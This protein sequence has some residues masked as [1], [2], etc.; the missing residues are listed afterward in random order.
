GERYAKLRP[1]VID[2]LELLGRERAL[3]YKT[4]LLTGLRKSELASLTVAQLQLDSEPPLVELEAADEKNREG[5]SLPLRPDLAA[6]LKAW[7][8][9]WLARLQV[10]AREKGDPIPTRLPPTA[11]VFTVP[12][13]LRKILDRDLVAAGIARRVKVDGKWKIEKRDDRGRT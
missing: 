7:M 13:A 6:D 8:S 2:R 5:N 11:R 3:I 9:D 4:I 10:E 1:E 12:S